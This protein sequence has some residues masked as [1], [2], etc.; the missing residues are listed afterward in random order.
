MP[1]SIPAAIAKVL[2]G[3]RGA[4]A[5]LYDTF[6]PGLLRRLGAR[7]GSLRGLDG[8][9][10]LQDTFLYLLGHD[11]RALERFLER[12]AG[13]EVTAE[14]LARFLWSA[15]CGIVSNRRRSLRRHPEAAFDEAWQLPAAGGESRSI[16]RDVLE[17]LAACLSRNGD[18]T[19]LYYQLRY[20]DGYSPAEIAA[21]AGWSRR[22]T[23][24]LKQALDEALDR[25]LE[26]LE[27]DAP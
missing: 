13:N 20:L 5:W 3:D 18:R 22:A 24:K 26:A 14:D 25:C 9:D 10:L 15:A 2:A 17:R 12:S 23:Y 6:A 7:F 19:Y 4:V 8:D 1:E 16:A 11:G 27:L 21:I